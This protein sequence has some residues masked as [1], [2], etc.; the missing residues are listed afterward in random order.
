VLNRRRLV[1]RTDRTACTVAYDLLAGLLA[2]FPAV[3]GIR[4]AM[5]PR[6]VQ[7]RLAQL[8]LDACELQVRWV[9]P[10]DGA[11]PQVTHPRG[12]PAP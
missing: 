5:R 7:D 12:A 4:P 9:W 1:L 11:D 6:D 3:H 2:V 8:T 10:R